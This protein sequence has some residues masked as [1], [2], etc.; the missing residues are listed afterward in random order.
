VAV[1]LGLAILA[2]LCLGPGWRRRSVEH[3]L[4]AIY[5]AHALPSE[6]NAATIYNRLLTAYLREEL[7]VPSP[8]LPTDSNSISSLLF[9]EEER[10]KVLLEAATRPKCFFPAL[11]DSAGPVAAMRW[12]RSTTIK[13]TSVMRQVAW[14][15]M[16][17]AMDDLDQGRL[18][19]ARE[20]LH[21]VAQTAAR[22][23][24]TAR[25]PTAER[26]PT[27]MIMESGPGEASG[28]GCRK[29]NSRTW[30]QS[31]GASHSPEAQ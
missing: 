3:R 29:S 25:D 23:F 28:N 9:S 11:C 13:R 1:V 10:M 24:S 4:A 22:S 8:G 30:K 19:A 2:V 31:C 16:A 21:C 7:R 12:M 15:I 18:D 17:A 6:E 5:A 26:R 14:S 20:K 27:G